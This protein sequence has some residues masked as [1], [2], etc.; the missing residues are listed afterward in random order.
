VSKKVVAL[1]SDKHKKPSG[2]RKDAHQI[3]FQTTRKSNMSKKK[4]ARALREDT[5]LYAITPRTRNQHT[6]MNSINDNKITFGIGSAG[7]GKTYIAG[8]MAADALQRGLCRKVIICRPI[9]EAGGERLGFLPGDLEDKCEPYLKPLFDVFEMYWYK[10]SGHFR[11]LMNSNRIEI[12]PLAYMR[13]RNFENVWILCD[14]AQNMNAN[15]MKMLLTRI[16]ENSKLIITGDPRQ[17]D[18]HDADGF[19]T[20]ENRLFDCP[21]VGFV[22]FHNEDVQREEIVKDILDRWED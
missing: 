8:M 4:A 20:A 12:C 13:G 21:D 7:S 19:E 2:I 6:F 17:R 5:S 16:A 22:R 11:N 3:D 15:L 18:R 14:E 9:I 10:S 1:F